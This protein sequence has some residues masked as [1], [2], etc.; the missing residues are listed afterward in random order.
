L[1]AKDLIA[2]ISCRL[3]ANAASM[4]VKHDGIATL[5]EQLSDVVDKA[6][7]VA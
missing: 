7:A 5:A 1:V 2:N 6:A 4:R 3:V